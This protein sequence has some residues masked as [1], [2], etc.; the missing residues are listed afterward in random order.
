MSDNDNRSTEHQDLGS[1]AVHKATSIMGLGGGVVTGAATS[2]ATNAA[3][4]VGENM[5]GLLSIL[6]DNMKHGKS[7]FHKSWRIGFG[8][9]GICGFTA[10]ALINSM[11]RP[12]FLFNAGVMLGTTFA[13][14]VVGGFAG[15]VV[16]LPALGLAKVYNFINHQL[17]N[18]MHKDYAALQ[19]RYVVAAKNILDKTPYNSFDS[20]EQKFLRP[21]FY[22]PLASSRLDTVASIATQNTQRLK[23]FA[24]SAD[25]RDGTSL[26]TEFMEA[27]Q[28]LNKNSNKQV[29]P[30]LL[31]GI[32][33][34]AVT[35]CAAIGA[36][37]AH[38]HNVA[39]TVAQDR[40][41]IKLDDAYFKKI[42]ASRINLRIT[43]ENVL[44]AHPNADMRNGKHQYSKEYFNETTDVMTSTHVSDL[45]C[46]LL[47]NEATFHGHYNTF[48]CD[49]KQLIRMIEKFEFKESSKCIDANKLSPSE[50]KEL[51]AKANEVKTLWEAQRNL[52]IAYLRGQKLDGFALK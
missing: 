51:A 32:G 52:N 42:E 43:I 46:G 6:I 40:Q 9:C 36:W 24:A 45:S 10:G 2:A 29:I 28:E 48:S 7:T 38:Q 3:R 20:D 47:F 21:I 34:T 27:K 25:A 17:R 8:I 22:K 23:D 30:A 12:D 14:L 44:R 50:K 18:K 31:T 33:F 16:G 39:S 26:L 11:Y 15:Y 4:G 35:S 49:A 1:S 5:G 41:F 13:G 19:Q 37:N